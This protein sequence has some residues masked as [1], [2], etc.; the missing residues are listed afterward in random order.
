MP[1]TDSPVVIGTLG[2]NHS[3]PADFRQRPVFEMLFAVERLKK[4]RYD[5][6]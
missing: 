4:A 2:S 5:L 1:F 3:I 6:S